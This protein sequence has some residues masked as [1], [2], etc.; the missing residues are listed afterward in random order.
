MYPK[1]ESVFNNRGYAKLNSND[2]RVA[3]SDFTISIQINSELPQPFFNRGI[4]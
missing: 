4:S 2:I 1:D 3:I